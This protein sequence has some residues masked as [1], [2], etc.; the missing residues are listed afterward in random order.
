VVHQFFVEEF[1][2]PFF[3]PRF[4]AQSFACLP[5]RGS[6]KAA[7]TLQYYLRHY[8]HQ[9]PCRHQNPLTPY[10]LKLD[11]TK[12]FYNIERKI[13]Y[14]IIAKKLKDKALK[15]LLAAI[16]FHNF[17]PKVPG[18]PIGNYTSQYFANIYLN[19]LDQYC[20]RVLK[21]KYYLRYMD[22]IVIIASS[23]AEA[24]YYK[25]KI[26]EFLADRLKLSLNQKST[27]QPIS[28]PV[29]FCGYKI[30]AKKLLIRNRA[31]HSL[32][33][34]LKDYEEGIDRL[35]RFVDRVEAWLGHALHADDGK[36]YALHILKNYTY[37][38]PRLSEDP[39]RKPDQKQNPPDVR[40]KP[41]KKADPII[42]SSRKAKTS[43][44]RKKI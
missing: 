22:D 26:A 34:I 8:H 17:D 5:K 20:K 4:I 29:D 13:L 30:S 14:K 41:T 23:K 24:R 16:L 38:F 40:P 9:T 21:I 25:R 3:V 43:R 12:F 10:T 15:S 6:L 44:S 35:P 27:I 33:L 19:E 11:I 36:S 1:I 32:R 18:I 31:K 39:V 42:I 2:K 28:H 37:L 7:Q